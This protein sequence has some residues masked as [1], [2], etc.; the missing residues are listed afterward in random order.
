MSDW[1]FVNRIHNLL[2]EFVIN[3][4]LFAHI[5]GIHYSSNKKQEV[6]NPIY[7]P[8]TTLEKSVNRSVDAQRRASEQRTNTYDAL[9]NSQSGEMRRV[10]GNGEYTTVSGGVSDTYN[11]LVHNG[12]P[13]QLHQSVQVL[14]EQNGDYSILRQSQ[15]PQSISL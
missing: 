12:Y 7:T 6:H 10:G 15:M 11:A 3:Q 8:T 14:N 4:R 2:P 5:A 1:I 13:R 9:V